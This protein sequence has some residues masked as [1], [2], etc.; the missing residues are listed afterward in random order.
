MTI[1]TRHNI[2]R[3]SLAVKDDIWPVIEKYL[4]DKMPHLDPRQRMFIGFYASQTLQSHF[5]GRLS[6]IGGNEILSIEE[7]EEEIQAIYAKAA[8]FVPNALKPLGR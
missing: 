1:L 3:L 2:D 8:R 6:A 5:I 7:I 4:H